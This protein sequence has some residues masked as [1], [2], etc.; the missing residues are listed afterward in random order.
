MKMMCVEALP[1]QWDRV[2]L[3]NKANSSLSGFLLNNVLLLADPAPPLRLLTH[4][5][6]RTACDGY[7]PPGS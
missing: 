7:D 1:P 5:P 6:G 3:V 4:G 2:A